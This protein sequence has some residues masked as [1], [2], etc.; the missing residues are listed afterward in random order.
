[1]PP[2]IDPNDFIHW[3]ARCDL[4]DD[5]DVDLTDLLIFV[6]DDP[7]N[8]LW[9]RRLAAG[10]AAGTT[11]DDEYGIFGRNAYAI[12]IGFNSTYMKTTTIV[13]E[14]TIQEQIIDLKDTIQFLER[15]WAG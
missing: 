2:G 13:P 8:W 7:Q 10:F 1:M 4:D 3:N 9:L 5:H 6:E 11:G 14:I 12:L 15:L